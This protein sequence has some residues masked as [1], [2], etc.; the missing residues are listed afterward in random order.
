ML[1]SG[2][3]ND[4]MYRK[5]RM[6]KNYGMALISTWFEEE[7]EQERRT[8]YRAPPLFSLFT[9][10]LLLFLMHRLRP[11]ALLEFNICG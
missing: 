10:S 6:K 11:D 1:I 5:V 2:I 9:F 4:E 8:E 7:T 3:T